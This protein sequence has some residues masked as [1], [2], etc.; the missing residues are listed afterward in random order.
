MKTTAIILIAY[1]FSLISPAISSA[2]SKQWTVIKSSGDTL[3]SCVIGTLEGTVVNW[4][5][6]KDAIQISVDSLKMLYRHGESHFWSGAGYGALAGVIAGTIIGT[7][8]YQKPTGP[9]AIDLGEG[10]AVAGGGILG[11]VTGFAIGGVIGAFSGG[12]E[13]HDLSREP[14]EE[15]IKILRELRGESQ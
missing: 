5:S 13:K 12:D 7:V 8:T 2:Q 11:G 9:W 14:T 3:R 6:S 15:K 4:V 10:P 1:F